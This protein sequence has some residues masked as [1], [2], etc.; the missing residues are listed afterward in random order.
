M[1]HSFVL[2]LVGFTSVGA[3]LVG[4][5]AIGL[6]R[7]CLRR[8]IGKM[9]SGV[10]WTLIFFMLNLTVGM[11]V[12]LVGRLLMRG[13]VSLYLA[14]DVTL[15]FLSLLQGLTFQWWQEWQT[16]SGRQGIGTGG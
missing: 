16:S 4:L 1:E 7:E 3:F 6:S 2:L 8:A 9:L 15:L 12:V 10:G 11:A 5:G 14:S 13:F